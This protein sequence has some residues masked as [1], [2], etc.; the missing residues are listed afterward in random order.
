MQ[1][2]SVAARAAVPIITASDAN[3]R[4]SNFRRSA[5]FL[6]LYRTERATGHSVP[7][8]YG[9]RITTSGT[10]D[11]VASRDV[12]TISPVMTAFP[13]HSPIAVN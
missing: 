1:A 5:T 10:M 2:Y 6:S 11:V 7:T 3:I 8:S 12:T 13:S 9:L 4:K